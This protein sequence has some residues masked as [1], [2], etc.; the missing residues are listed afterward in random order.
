MPSRFD[1]VPHI[2]LARYNKDISGSDVFTEKLAKTIDVS[3]IHLMKRKVK[4]ELRENSTKFFD[5]ASYEL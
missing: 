3:S 5:V 1:F 4:E 2:T